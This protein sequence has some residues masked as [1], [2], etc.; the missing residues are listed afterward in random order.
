MKFRLDTSIGGIRTLGRFIYRFYGNLYGWTITI[1]FAW[2][3]AFVYVVR[4]DWL[5]AN[6]FYEG[7]QQGLTASLVVAVHVLVA[8]NTVAFLMES[9]PTIGPISQLPELL[10]QE[11]ATAKNAYQ[12][13]VMGLVIATFMAGGLALIVL[14]G[15][16]QLLCKPSWAVIL[17]INEAGS[18]LIFSLFFLADYVGYLACKIACTNERC[19][20]NR[21]CDIITHSMDELKLLILAVDLPGLFGVIFIALLSHSYYPEHIQYYYWHGFIAGAIGLHIAFSQTALALIAARH[22]RPPQ[23]TDVAGNLGNSAPIS[24]SGLPRPLP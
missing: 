11:K 14:L 7:T 13:F 9:S 17:R 19:K 2:Q 23:K 16:L 22:E 12:V 5:S 15:A 3:A 21:N 4:H 18:I 6:L 8:F 24:V 1:F 20:A 10:P